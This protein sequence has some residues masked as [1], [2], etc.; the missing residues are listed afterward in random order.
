MIVSD[1]FLVMPLSTCI[2]IVRASHAAVIMGRTMPLL[3][4]EMAAAVV[5]ARVEEFVSMPAVG[6]A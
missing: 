4:D 1:R 6:E 2:A 5:C 3:P